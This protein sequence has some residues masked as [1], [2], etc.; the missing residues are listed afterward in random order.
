MI[1][2]LL[3]IL[4]SFVAVT[5][6]SLFALIA[7]IRNASGEVISKKKQE[8]SDKKAR[9]EQA[10][11]AVENNQSDGREEEILDYSA[12]KNTSKTLS[13]KKIADSQKPGLFR[14]LAQLF[15]GKPSRKSKGLQVAKIPKTQINC[16]M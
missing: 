5:G 13:Q 14:R 7:R 6:L 12:D 8:Y 11:L 3:V 4:V 10:K 16:W 15:A 9:M 2:L 1:I